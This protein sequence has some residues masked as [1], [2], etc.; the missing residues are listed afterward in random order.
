MFFF[1][2]P[3]TVRCLL[4]VRSVAPTAGQIKVRT[5]PCMMDRDY[6]LPDDSYAASQ[7]RGLSFKARLGR[8]NNLMDADATA[9]AANLEASYSAKK[10]PYFQY[11][12]HLKCLFVRS[13]YFF[14]GQAETNVD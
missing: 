7:H 8:T 10:N 4:L 2:F 13:Y 12:Y 6:I 11:Q 1:L 5:P 3:R 9:T 14:G